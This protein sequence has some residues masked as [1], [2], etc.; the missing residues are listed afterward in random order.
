MNKKKYEKLSVPKVR[1]EDAIKKAGNKSR[2]AEMLGLNR[3]NISM[4][5]R[6]KREFLPDSQACRIALHFPE[7]VVKD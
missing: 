6:S 3:A 1:L 5:T 4:W 2:L 7:L